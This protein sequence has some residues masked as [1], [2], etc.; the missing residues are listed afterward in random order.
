MAIELSN[1]TFTELEDIVPASGVAQ[2]LNTGIANT[3]AGGDIITGIATDS[4]GIRNFG[5]I[6][7]GDDNDTITGTSMSGSG[8]E[9]LSNSSIDTGNGNDIITAIGN[10]YILYNNGTINTGNGDDS[11]IAEENGNLPLYN[12]S[13]DGTINTDSGNDSIILNGGLYNSGVVLLGD[14]NDS[15]ALTPSKFF[16]NR[17][18]DNYN[19]I[20]TGDGDDTIT[21]TGVIYNEGILN[22]DNGTDLIIFDGAFS[23]SGVVFLGE[24]NDSIIGD[25]DLP[26]DR[27]L[28][29][30]NAIDTGNGDDYISTYTHIYNE[31]IINTGN[32]ND[33]IYSRFI[34]NNGG[35]IITGDGQD[36]IY[37]SDGFE[38]GP[39]SSGAWFLGE[40][41]DYL[42]GFGNGDFYGGNG[43]DIINFSQATGTYTV[44][45]WGEGPDKSVIFT[46]G[47]QIM[48]TS[49][50]E[51]L[52][53]VGELYDFASLTPGQTITVGQSIFLTLGEG[54]DSII[55][56]GEIFN[57]D[58]IY[59]GNGNDFI[60]TYGS[61]N[62]E[63]Y[64]NGV[65]LE[66]NNDYFYG[67]GSGYFSGGNGEDT[68][69]L[70]PGSY[71]IKIAFNTVKFTEDITFTS[72]SKKAMMNTFEFEQ[73]IVGG[74]TY[75]FTSL[76]AGQIITVAQQSIWK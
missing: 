61:F 16:P 65:N 63:G 35:A 46:K 8:I 59:A 1:L 20:D 49:G 14:G 55:V 75:N 67:F 68:L 19:T 26:S 72:P 28:E 17:A 64:G 36:S 10:A 60:I 76:T 38:S 21:S 27:F 57:G 70:L 47:N 22:T 15:F 54:N 43:R 13:N 52:I 11:I 74:T 12:S 39:N 40:D 30:F 73:L 33:S 2:I 69:E 51:L 24:G 9:N 56:T 34:Y 6:N 31:G 71:T 41:N 44:G 3:L 42:H 50:F 25:A 48:I 62:R 5:S 4:G 58:S 45:I 32:G 18:L 37:T 53:N 7:T 23:N 66:N 29:N